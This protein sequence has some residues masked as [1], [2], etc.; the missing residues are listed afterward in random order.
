METNSV[1]VNGYMAATR[2]ANLCYNLAQRDE[3]PNAKEWERIRKAMGEDQRA[4]DAASGAIADAL[5]I[6]RHGSKS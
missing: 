3:P 4:W 5:R 1:A 2:M 6:K